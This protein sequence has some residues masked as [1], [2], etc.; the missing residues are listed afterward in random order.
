[1]YPYPLTDGRKKSVQNGS[2]SI[3]TY[4][5]SKTGAATPGNAI[6]LIPS[7]RADLGVESFGNTTLLENSQDVSDHTH[8]TFMNNPSL[9]EQMD[10]PGKLG[11]STEYSLPTDRQKAN[12]S[13]QQ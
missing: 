7:R 3:R 10:N 12:S 8:G 13:A 11:A 1:M 6:A 4:F 2:R 9:I 5:G